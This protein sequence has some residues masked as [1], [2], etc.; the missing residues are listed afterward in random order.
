MIEAKWLRQVLISN[1]QK[2]GETYI[3]VNFIR[4]I[5]HLNGRYMWEA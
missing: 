4:S 2:K 1:S 5:F 3:M